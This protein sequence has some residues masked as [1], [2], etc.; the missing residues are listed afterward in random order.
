[1]YLLFLIFSIYTILIIKLKLKMKIN[2]NNN[3]NNITIIIFYIP[4]IL[5]IL[6]GE[7]TS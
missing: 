6:F 5:I 2:N 4:Y 7:Y 3:D 1:M